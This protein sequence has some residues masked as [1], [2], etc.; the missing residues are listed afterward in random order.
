LFFGNYNTVDGE[1]Y[2]DTLFEE[3][4]CPASSV[5]NCGGGETSFSGVDPAPNIQKKCF[6]FN[7]ISISN[8]GSNGNPIEF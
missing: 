4:I 1:F 6:G 3:I 8:D 2:L 7:L 5:F